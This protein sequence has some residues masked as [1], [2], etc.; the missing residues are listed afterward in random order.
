MSYSKRLVCLTVL[1]LTLDCHMTCTR[2]TDHPRDR[3][4]RFRDSLLRLLDG[5]VSELTGRIAP[6]ES[7]VL[8]GGYMTRPEDFEA[9]PVSPA[10]R[11]RLAEISPLNEVSALALI[12][13]DRVLQY[14]ILE[15]GWRSQPSARRRQPER[16]SSTMLITGGDYKITRAVTPEGRMALIVHD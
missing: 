15:D 12:R 4:V 8:V 14:T 1:L 6:E 2:H 5:S 13:G 16:A 7:Y 9:L 10:L 3:V 11:G